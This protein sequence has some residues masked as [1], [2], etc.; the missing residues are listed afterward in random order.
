M[1]EQ[2]RRPG[3]LIV[4][5]DGTTAQDIGSTLAAQGYAVSIVGSGD[6]AFQALQC[7]TFDCVLLDQRLEHPAVLAELSRYPAQTV[8]LI[9]LVSDTGGSPVE[10]LRRGAYDYVTR[11]IDLDLLKIRVARAIERTTLARTMRELLEDLQ[12]RVDEARRDLASAYRE[13]DE[14]IHVV[15]HEL[16]GPLSAIEGYAETLADDAVPADA[17][18]RFCA[19]ITTASKRMGRLIED[20]AGSAH[21]PGVQLSLQLA[22]WDLVSI[23][24]EQIGLANVGSV[25]VTLPSQPLVAWCDCDRVAQVVANLLSNAMK[26]SDAS[27]IQVCLARVDGEARLTV[28]DSGP[29]IPRERL[30]DIFEPHVRLA[31]SDRQAVGSGLGLYVAR[32]IAEAHGGSLVVDPDGP[33]AT[34][35]FSLPLHGLRT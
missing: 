31:G 30:R 13:R 15:A 17:R 10:T 3:I 28:S 2:R 24:R 11:P 25:S 19:A 1:P 8:A 35:V 7:E 26:Y 14:F 16:S 4:E 20:L 6:E 5:E 21:A 27:H 33:G 9:A 29:G 32:C 23:V 18:L 12:D 22:E 34:F